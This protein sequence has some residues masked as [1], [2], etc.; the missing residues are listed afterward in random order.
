MRITRRTSGGRGEYEISEEFEGISPHDLVGHHIILDLGNG[1]FLDT[2]TELR[3][4]GGKPRLRMRTRGGMQIHRQVA[5]TLLMPHPVRAD[6]SLGTGSLVIRRDQYAINHMHVS[7]VSLANGAVIVLLGSVTLR[8]QMHDAEEVAFGERMLLLRRIWAEKENLPESI[9]SL[10][11]SHEMHIT[12][13]RSVGVA[14][15]KIIERLE[16]LVSENAEDLD[17]AYNEGTDVLDALT[18]VLSLV[19]PEPVVQLDDVDPE[20]PEV[21]RRVLREWKRWGNSRGADS[22]KFR[23]AVRTAY[24]STC[25]VCGEHLPT[26]VKN[27]R[28]GVDAAHI[29]PW[30]QY[31]LDDVSNGICLCKTHHWAFDEGLIRIR[32][33]DGEYQVEVPSDMRASILLDNPNFS[34]TSLCKYEGSIPYERLPED[35]AAR[36]QE[37]YLRR[38]NEE[39]DMV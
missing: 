3:V 37:A 7:G 24:N 17:I 28:P 6:Y 31:D 27:R 15:E 25:A 21:R 34:F 36:P 26:T 22:A 11:A 12:G 16:A 38:L 1:L 5:A 32:F 13:N 2:N 30:A 20:E 29:L 23:A 9:A 4:Q 8:N 39:L 10:I 35:P 19:R 33:D 14:V 18:Q